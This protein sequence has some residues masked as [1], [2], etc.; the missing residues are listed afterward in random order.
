MHYHPIGTLPEH[1]ALREVVARLPFR[2]FAPF[3]RFP[4]EDFAQKREGSDGHKKMDIVPLQRSDW[5]RVEETYDTAI[6]ERKSLLESVPEL[7]YCTNNPHSLAA[8]EALTLGVRFLCERYSERFTL[9]E[10]GMRDSVFQRDYAINP[11]SNHSLQ[12]LGGVVEEDLLLLE[13]DPREVYRVTSICACFPSHWS[14]H[15]KL[16]QSLAEI[17]ESVP[18]LNENLR[19]KIDSMMKNLPPERPVTRINMLVNF[20][21]R[22]S[23]FPAL[24]KERPYPV[25]PLEYSSIGDQLYLRNERETIVKL[26]MTLGVLFTIKTYQIP[27]SKL[28]GWACSKLADFHEGFDPVYRDRYRKLSQEEGVMVV[29]WLRERAKIIPGDLEEQG[30]RE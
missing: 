25:S 6:S 17:H 15:Q 23:Q 14:I 29:E 21:P 18:N 16:G 13:M 8:K 9:S 19:S 5:F 12:A 7:T 10:A 1:S 11:R 2:E 30:R 4:S 28:P 24:V 26:P 27:F 3:T 22:W 20:D